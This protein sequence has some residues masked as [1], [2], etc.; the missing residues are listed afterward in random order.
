[1]CWRCLSHSV[2]G[3][4]PRVVCFPNDVPHKVRWEQS[5]M[6]SVGFSWSAHRY[7]RGTEVQKPS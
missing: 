1:M 2:A 6:H 3:E 7:Y 4:D 5:R